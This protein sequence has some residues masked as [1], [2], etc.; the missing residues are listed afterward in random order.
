MLM[1]FEAQSASRSEMQSKAQFDRYVSDLLN[2]YPS[3]LVELALVETLVKSWLT[4]PMQRGVAFLSVAHEQLKQWQTEKETSESVSLSL[5]PSQFSQ[6]T[7]L[8][9]KTAFAAFMALG[10]E[11]DRCTLSHPTS[12]S[13]E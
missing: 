13:V 7:G 6:I 9:A 8:D 5:S 4:V 12:A 3:G 11:G 10:E 2:Q 1:G